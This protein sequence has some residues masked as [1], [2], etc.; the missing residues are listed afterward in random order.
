MA[1]NRPRIIG[2]RNIGMIQLPE[3]TALAAIIGP[4]ARIPS[5]CDG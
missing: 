2:T 3:R 5:Q 4:A 1:A